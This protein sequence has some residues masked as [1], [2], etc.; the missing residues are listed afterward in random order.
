MHTLTFIVPWICICCVLT[1]HKR[2]CASK[3]VRARWQKKGHEEWTEHTTN[4]RQRTADNVEYQWK[5]EMFDKI[6]AKYR[7]MRAETSSWNKAKQSETIIMTTRHSLGRTNKQ[8][9]LLEILNMRGWSFTTF[10]CKPSIL[11]TFRG[12]SKLSNSGQM[13]MKYI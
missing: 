6:D 2:F 5:H 8:V 13:Q 10:E 12:K 3:W 11:T 4:V 9:Y 1:S 7:I